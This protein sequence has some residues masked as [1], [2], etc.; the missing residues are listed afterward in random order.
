MILDD[1]PLFQ[2]YSFDFKKSHTIKDGGI[3]KIIVSILFFY[4]VA[5]INPKCFAQTR[6]EYAF[7]GELS[8]IRN[9]ISQPPYDSFSEYVTSSFDAYR[10]FHPGIINDKKI[11]L[12]GLILIPKNRDTI[13][14][15]VFVFSHGTTFSQNVPSNWSHPIH[16]EALPAMNNYI[17]FLPDYLGYGSSSDELPAY[18]NKAVTISN[19]NNFIVE[20]LR[21]LESLEV[22]HS[23]NIYLVGFSQGGHAVLGLSEKNSE[24][25]NEHYTIAATISI[26]GPV[27]INSNFKHILNQEVFPHSTYIPYLL[28][29]YR[30]YYNW[31]SSLSEY[32]NSPYDSITT[33]FGKRNLSLQV[34]NELTTDSIDILIQE[35]FRKS[36]LYESNSYMQMKKDFKENSL[37]SFQTKAPIYLIHGRLDEDVPLNDVENFYKK[38]MLINESGLLKLSVLDGLNHNASGLLGMSITL[39]YLNQIFQDE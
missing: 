15:G 35:N 23:N 16:I 27:D 29:S 32:F 10:L 8:S 20:G 14:D 37:N 19:I 12:S 25:E 26:G 18:M 13:K 22:P 21:A 31:N 6:T 2:R 24:D 7:A 39:D 5:C 34:L 1:S 4:T 11:E 28:S 17:T 33:E 38:M 9:I 3:M 36:F 30:H